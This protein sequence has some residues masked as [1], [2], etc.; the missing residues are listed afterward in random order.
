MKKIKAFTL[1]ELLVVISIIAVLVSIMMP[2]LSKARASAQRIVCLNNL[3]NLGMGMEFYLQEN[4]EIFPP[5]RDR[6]NIMPINVGKFIRYQPRWIW[7]IDYGVGHVISPEKYATQEEFSAALDMDNEYFICPTVKGAKFMRSIRNGSYGFNYQYL[8]NTRGNCNFPN[9][10]TRV[11]SPLSTILFGD[12][13]GAG[14]PHGE[15]AYLMDPPKMATSRGANKFSP[16]AK[17]I[18]P[19]GGAEK[20][21]PADA[22]HGNKANMV[23]MDGHASAFTYEELGYVV[24]PETERPIEKAN[25]LIDNIGNNRMWTGIGRDEHN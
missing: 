6:A 5:D 13:R 15:H 7:F 19:I 10:A 18:I 25:T 20:Y 17:D 3:R 11:K 14:I 2:A 21:S 8:S 24:D 22:R 9:K 4:N 1:I 12:S 23:Y 16:A